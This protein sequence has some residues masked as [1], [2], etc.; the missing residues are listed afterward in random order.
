MEEKVVAGSISKEA[1]AAMIAKERRAN[2]A[3]H[4]FC[5]N[6]AAVIGLIIVLIM[7]FLGVF[8][9]LLATHDP[10]QINVLETYLPP[11]TNGH[12]FGTDDLGRD[13]FSRILY[14]ARMSIV[15]AVGATLLGGA[16]G[17]LLGLLS[18]YIGG[19]VDAVIMRIM[20][21]LFAFPF[22]L[23][24]I[25]LV[26]ILGSGVFNVILAIGIGNVPRFARVVRSKVMVAKNEE[27]CNAERI[28][29]A[30]S[31]RTMFF[32]VLPNTVSEVVVYA[33]LSVGSAIISEA[34]LS[35]LGL[36]ILIPTPSWGN[37]LRGGRGC[38]TTSPHIA[39]IAGLFIF[40]SVI[41]FNLVGDGIRDVMDPKMKK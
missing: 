34:S 24:S 27:Y 9:P 30:S 6:K 33:T 26:T 37:I 18:G 14:G 2:N 11:M 41:G 12:L 17:I 1:Q 21:G 13:L 10:N 7:V 4:K 8:A 36:G 38:L 15:V 5:R 29:G 3:W 16:I 22:I 31:L 19:W 23:L 40:V 32:H 35:F 20:D 28:L 39:L 25:L